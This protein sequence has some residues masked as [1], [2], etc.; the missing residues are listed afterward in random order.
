M[1][2]LSTRITI[3]TLI[4][5]IVM[6]LLFLILFLISI[7]SGMRSWEERA[8]QD[9]NQQVEVF[10][11]GW[12]SSH[13][14]VSLHEIQASDV[15]ERI[16]EMSD[17]L[18]ILDPDGTVIHAYSKHF[19]KPEDDAAHL[20]WRIVNPKRNEPGPP[21]PVEINGEAAA[22]FVAIP[23]RFQSYRYSRLIVE[24]IVNLFFPFSIVALSLSLLAGLYL[25]RFTAASADRLAKKVSKLAS[26]ERGIVFSEEPVT[27]LDSISQ[28]VRKLHRQLIGATIQ[29]TQWVNDISHDLKT[30]IA[31]MQ[32]QL[33]GI[34]DG[35]FEADKKRV[36]NLLT[37]LS[38][39]RTLVEK[40]MLL[41]Y[42]SGPDIEIKPETFDVTDYLE[43][44]LP[45]YQDRAVKEKKSLIVSIEPGIVNTD[46]EILTRILSNL[47][48]N[49]IK[50]SP[51]GAEITFTNKFQDDFLSIQII[52]TGNIPDDELP[53]IYNSLYRGEKSRSSSGNGMG[54]TIVKKLVELLH[55][56][57]LVESL[58]DTFGDGSEGKVRASLNLPLG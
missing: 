19:D 22:K 49:A 5:S 14:D 18:D 8:V 41:T 11:K 54:L 7:T 28:S 12:I 29:Q 16:I 4:V 17:R 27:E 46:K 10:L 31:A 40:F 2:R 58:P 35:V 6:L 36:Q 48:V 33:E 38:H 47:L 3:T 23:V 42:L 50:Y 26:G 52:N 55:G 56:T 13:P 15:P 20:I 34:H 53:F 44:R 25:S 39:V 57:I 9:L 45:A 37:E 51:A 43:E 1:R 24:K 21:A 30:P 32:I